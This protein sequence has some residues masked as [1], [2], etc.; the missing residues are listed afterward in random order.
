MLCELRLLVLLL[1][2]TNFCLLGDFLLQ[3]HFRWPV[4]F[5]ST[6]VY[7]NQHHRK[8]I[9]KRFYRE[10]NGGFWIHSPKCK[11]LHHRTYSDPKDAYFAWVA[12]SGG[13]FFSVC[14]DCRLF[15]VWFFPGFVHWLVSL[16]TRRVTS[17][18]LQWSKVIGKR[19]RARFEL[20]FLNSEFKLL[21]S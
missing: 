7:C 2:L 20:G 18:L 17:N 4:S 9:E 3:V 11:P 14:H 19:V 21:A 15:V 13:F 6:I 1:I 12:I 5:W 16:L 8:S 10:L